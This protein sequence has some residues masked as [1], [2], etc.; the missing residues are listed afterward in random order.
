MVAV[1]IPSGA[2]LSRLGVR[3]TLIL[4]QSALIPMGMALPLLHNMGLLTFW[5][6]VDI[7]AI[8]AALSP[9]YS[10]GVNLLVAELCEPHCCVAGHPPASPGGSWP[11]ASTRRAGSPFWRRIKMRLIAHQGVR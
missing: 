3:R 5:G 8:N 2:V 6:I 1:G 7:A 10:A 9:A 11:R 4:A